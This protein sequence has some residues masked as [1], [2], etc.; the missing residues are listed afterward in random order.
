V[1][2]LPSASLPLAPPHKVPLR[3]QLLQLVG[4][5]TLLFPGACLFPAVLPFLFRLAFCATAAC[6]ALPPTPSPAVFD[7]AHCSVALACYCCRAV[8]GWQADSGPAGSAPP[9]SRYRSSSITGSVAGSRPGSAAS[10]APPPPRWVGGVLRYPHIS[11][12]PV[13]VVVGCTGLFGTHFLTGA[14]ARQ[15]RA[16][17][18]Q[19]SDVCPLA[20]PLCPAGALPVVLAAPR[21]ALPS[22][23]SLAPC[24]LA[25][26]LWTEPC[27]QHP[28]SLRPQLRHQNPQAQ[29]QWCRPLC[30]QSPSA[31][32]PPEPW[33]P[34]CPWPPRSA[35]RTAVLWWCRGPPP[36]LQHR[37]PRRRQCQ[38]QSPLLQ[39]LWWPQTLATPPSWSCSSWDRCTAPRGGGG[40]GYH[41]RW[42]CCVPCAGALLLL[43]GRA[44]G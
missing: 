33:T 5:A 40:G 25:R 6:V 1:S 2:E 43:G 19:F 24:V 16:F 11:R 31:C 32:T 13:C 8:S 41:P 20:V 7:S 12:T 44:G 37:L 26:P 21:G 29:L 36:P 3:E 14:C 28:P 23:P 42:S 35:R 15:S 27:R 34:T 9:S 30:L 18:L 22:C 39:R 38:L 17:F 10:P 4:P